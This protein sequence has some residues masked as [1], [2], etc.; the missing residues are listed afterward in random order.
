MWN[1]ELIFSGPK[2]FLE[3]TDD[4]ISDVL[5]LQVFDW[6]SLM[7][8][9]FKLLSCAAQHDDFLGEVRVHLHQAFEQAGEEIEYTQPLMLKS[10][11]SRGTLRF[12]VTWLPAEERKRTIVQEHVLP[13]GGAENGG[14]ILPILRDSKLS[15]P[16]GLSR[17]ARGW[18]LMQDLAGAYQKLQ[19]RFMDKQPKLTDDEQRSAPLRFRVRAKLIV[20]GWSPWSKWSERVQMPVLPRQSEPLRV[21]PLSSNALAVGWKLPDVLGCAIDGYELVLCD[22]NGAS[23]ASP[24]SSVIT[25]G[26]LLLVNEG[27]N[28]KSSVH[29]THS[30]TSEINLQLAADLS[31]HE[32]FSSGRRLVSEKRT[33]ASW[34]GELITPNA[35]AMLPDHSNVYP[36]RLRRAITVL[37]DAAS[38][39][40]CIVLSFEDEDNRI[41]SSDGVNF[42]VCFRPLLMISSNT[43]TSGRTSRIATTIDS[44]V[45]RWKDG[46]GRVPTKAQAVSSRQDVACR[47]WIRRLMPSFEQAVQASLPKWGAAKPEPPTISVLDEHTTYVRWSPPSFVACLYSRAGLFADRLPIKATTMSKRVLMWP[48]AAQIASSGRAQDTHRLI[49]RVTDLCDTWADDGTRPTYDVAPAA[50]DGLRLR[51]VVTEY[52]VEVRPLQEGKSVKLPSDVLSLDKLAPREA[53][54]L[55]VRFPYLPTVNCELLQ[56]AYNGSRFFTIMADAPALTKADEGRAIALV[57]DGEVKDDGISRGKGDPGAPTALVVDGEYRPVMWHRTDA[58]P[59]DSSLVAS[60]KVVVE[61]IRRVILADGTSFT[62]PNL[63]PNLTCGWLESGISYGWRVRARAT[64]AGWSEW[65]DWAIECCPH[66]GAPTWPLYVA[67]ESD[68]PRRN[69]L[70]IGGVDALGTELLALEAKS[71]TSMA[72]RWKAPIVSACEVAHFE[73]Q[74]RASTLDG[75]EFSIAGEPKFEDA[76]IGDG[77]FELGT[78][79]SSRALYFPCLC[80][81]LSHLASTLSPHAL[82]LASLLSMQA[83]LKNV[84]PAVACTEGA[85]DHE[86]RCAVRVRAF[87]VSSTGVKQFSE[88]SSVAELVMPFVKSPDALV[89]LAHEVNQLHAMWSVPM[90][91]SCTVVSYRVQVFSHEGAYEELLSQGGEQPTGQEPAKPSVDVSIPAVLGAEQMPPL[92]LSGGVT[93]AALQSQSVSVNLL[94]SKTQFDEDNDAVRP[95]IHCLRV[96]AEALIGGGSKIESEWSQPF[97]PVTMPFLGWR[98]EV[99]PVTARPVSK[100]TAS[101]DVRACKEKLCKLETVPEISKRFVS[102]LFVS[103]FPVLALIAFDASSHTAQFALSSRTLILSKVP[104]SRRV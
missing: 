76:L 98:N 45:S 93:L 3:A 41:R 92:D 86:R 87:A 43:T 82:D 96:R 69:P 15:L 59:P 16:N 32:A 47:P 27:S 64:I 84:L 67:A 50:L 90:A 4:D 21:E 56:E 97:A 38:R 8:A 71:A 31:P 78:Q 12:T 94:V 40:R 73:V 55:G 54:D 17:S 46:K 18:T 83:V 88:W 89:G 36:S 5:L 20:G 63:A 79:A 68:A 24:Q 80:A 62:V 91:I 53:S 42:H 65:S 66:V 14:R 22:A 30:F 58:K 48:E 2:G 25:E 39:R 77:D 81:L 34:A 103:L 7:K 6:D 70:A 44:I 19:L 11:N 101:V 102:K 52:L 74:L 9:P 57:S 10:G 100:T 33:E 104:K 26:E 72:V 95:A 35:D 75:T 37:A 60:I 49:E 1:E 61:E 99:A 13:I 51:S 29:G 85:I 23:L 28:A